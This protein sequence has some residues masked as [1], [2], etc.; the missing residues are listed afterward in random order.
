V[1][2]RLSPKMHHLD[3]LALLLMIT[4]SP[5]PSSNL[6]IRRRQIAL[7]ILKVFGW[8]FLFKRLLE[9]SKDTIRVDKSP[10]PLHRFFW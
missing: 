10:N 7:H 3:S 4:P 9:P 2:R 8:D 1:C 5:P 6:Q